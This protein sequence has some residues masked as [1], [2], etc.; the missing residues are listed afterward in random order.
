MPAFSSHLRLRR[1]SLLRHALLTL[2]GAFVV[3]S[4]TPLAAQQQPVRLLV[5]FPPGGS[6]DV[7]ARAL[8]E[9]MSRRLQ[10]NVIVENRPGAGG[11]IAASVLRQSAADGNTLLL[12]NSHALSMIPLTVRD[13]GYDASTDFSAVS[14]VATAPDVLAVNP[15]VVGP[16]SGLRDL[17]DWA[18]A[19]PDRANIGVPAPN[20]DPA[21]AVRLL[22]RAFRT[23]LNAIPYRGDA[24]VVQD[25][26]AGQ[27]PAGIGSAGAMLPAARAGRL[28][29]I[30]ING[31]E[32]LPSLPEVATYAEQG[33]AGYGT[34]G[35]VAVMAPA[36]LPPEL[37]GRYNAA[38][39]DVVDSPAFAQ[40]LSELAIAPAS[41]TPEALT[42]RIRETTRGFAAL[43]D[44][45]GFRIP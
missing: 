20:S 31:P 3:V 32:R 29:I 2:A 21:F 23:E 45:I 12:S 34:S 38:I 1:R 18:R 41:S 7:V 19:H 6:A 17:V 8:A 39:A 14:L 4:S 37:I 40:R 27:I 16:A 5:G 22:A 24:S 11:Q 28:K 26:I 35:F 30:A 25:L 44:R 13:P 9:A 15:Q 36:G 42:Q 33:L 43:I 10:R